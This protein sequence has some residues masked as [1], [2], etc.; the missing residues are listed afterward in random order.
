MSKILKIVFVN[1]DSAIS[2][3]IKTVEELGELL[4]IKCEKPIS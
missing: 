1:G 2:S 3:L 4:Q